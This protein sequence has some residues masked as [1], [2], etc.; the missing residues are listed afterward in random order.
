M[1]IRDIDIRAIILSNP[2][3][4]LDLASRACALVRK[5]DVPDYGIAPALGVVSV[6]STQTPVLADQSPLPAI[7]VMEA[8]PLPDSV[9]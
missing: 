7:T 8:T 5:E 4:D 6:G 3:A 1:R 2:N 9:Q